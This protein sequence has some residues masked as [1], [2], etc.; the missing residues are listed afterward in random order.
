MSNYLLNKEGIVCRVANLYF[1]LFNFSYLINIQFH[2]NTCAL[3]VLLNK[4]QKEMSAS[5]KVEPNFIL[6]TKS[7]DS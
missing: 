2:E 6:D 3:N 4:I 5:L 1:C 7:L